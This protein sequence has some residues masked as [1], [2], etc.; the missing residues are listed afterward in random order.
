VTF[1]RPPLAFAVAILAIV[2]LALLD[3]LRRRPVVLVVASLALFPETAEVATAAARSRRREWRDLVL[4]C[5]AACLLALAAGGPRLPR[6]AG[7]GR[8]V[9][10]LLARGASLRAREGK[11]TRFDLAREEARR[12]LAALAPEDRVDLHLAP[13]ADD[14]PRGA[15]DP[16]AARAALDQVR[17]VDAPSALEARAAL[18]SA[19]ASELARDASAL[20]V[21]VISDRPAASLAFAPELAAAARF[22]VVGEPHANRG[23]VALASRRDERGKETLLAAVTNAA[24]EPATLT[25][26]LR[27]AAG[28]DDPG[29]ETIARTLSLAAG[30]TRIELVLAD[31]L[32]R[33]GAV[34]A[35]LSGEDALA[36]DD[37][38]IALRAADAPVKIAIA[39]N[40]GAPLETALRSVPGTTVETFPEG[41]APVTGHDLTILSWKDDS[42]RQPRGSVVFVCPPE[43]AAPVVRPLRA[44]LALID[45]WFPGT[46]LV[47][48]LEGVSV[49][50]SGVPTGL[51]FKPLV[52]DASGHTLLG[53]SAPTPDTF[54]LYVGFALPRS[55]REPWA[56]TPSFPRFWANVVERVRERPAE[57]AELRA[58]PTGEPL[59]LPRPADAEPGDALSVTAPSGRARLVQDRYVPLEAGI[60]R[61]RAE[62]GKAS[63]AFAAALRDPGTED[64]RSARGAPFTRAVLALLQRPSTARASAS[65]AWLLA[66]LGL[67]FAGA[68]W[69]LEGQAAQAPRE[70]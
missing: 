6:G 64:L 4:K 13:V 44:D 45:A 31:A 29:G 32:A 38:V 30:E 35:S 1:D 22:A 51:P 33:T 10:I 37:R 56:S 12:A 34:F 36:V 24:D 60:H 16:D 17:L 63:V 52:K 8:R 7:A 20:P 3:R 57:P 9:R 59:A 46:N 50:R 62:H 66:L 49:V 65:L 15:L 69:A 14:E 58:E 70:R 39:G 40:L 21:F 43:P 26:T 19:A 23:I 25:L 67:A 54:F 42:Q 18:L 5:L 68:A 61:V 41:E 28:P 27:L 2:L 48:G 47:E 53:A 11:G 55:S